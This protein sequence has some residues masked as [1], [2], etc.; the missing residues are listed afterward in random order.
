MHTTGSKTSSGIRIAA[1]GD[2]PDARSW[3]SRSMVAMWARRR[4]RRGSSSAEED[5]DEEDALWSTSILAA[6]AFG[7]PSTREEDEVATKEA[8]EEGPGRLLPVEDDTGGPSIAKQWRQGG[9]NHKKS[10]RGDIIFLVV[11]GE[12]QHTRDAPHRHPRV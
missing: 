9:L 8:A 10:G 1:L 11:G 5:E 12:A 6:L 4:A 7:G 2:A 3:R